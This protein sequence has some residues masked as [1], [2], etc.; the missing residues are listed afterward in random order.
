MVTRTLYDNV[1]KYI[2]RMEWEEYRETVEDIVRL[3]KERNAVIL[4]HNYQTPEIFHGVADFKGDSLALAIEA[5][6][7]TADVIVQ[8]GVFFM[9]ET[10]KIMSP[11]KTVLIPDRLAGCSLAESITA[12]DV[13]RLREAF[14][15]VPIVTYVNTSAEVKAVSDVCCT[16]SNALKI[17]ESLPG[18]TVLMIPDKFLAQNTQKHTKKKILTWEG[19]CEVHERFTG[20][21]ILAWKAADPTLVVIAHPECPLDVTA[22]SDFVGSTSAMIRH[23]ETNRPPKVML[24]TECSMASNLAISFPDVQFSQPCNLCPHMN[25]ITL[26]KIKDSLTFMKEE[27]I[28]DPTIILQARKALDRMVE[29]S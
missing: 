25:R 1:R 4:A 6:K 21:Q 7:T 14:P 12:A 22:V 27:V 29:M 11:H 19:S 3:K 26:Q 17:V 5:S 2:P 18:D 24:I 28:V 16:S 8:A 20:E 9:A 13:L 15:G 10:S 23:I